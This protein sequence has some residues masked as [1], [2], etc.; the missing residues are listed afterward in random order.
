MLNDVLCVI[1][2][3]HL[4][5]F[6]LAAT[7]AGFSNTVSVI[8][9]NKAIPVTGREGPEGCE[10]SRLSHLPDNRLPQTALTGWAL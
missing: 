4:L 5:L 7:Y 1:V 3:S 9:V 10:T 8:K 2:F 6:F